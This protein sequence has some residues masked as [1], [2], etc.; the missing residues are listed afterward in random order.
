M[1]T[2]KKLGDRDAKCPYFRYHT[3]QNIVCEGAIPDTS[4][5]ILFESEEEKEKHYKIYCAEKWT[6]CEQAKRTGQQYADE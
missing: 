6:Y 4:V 2:Q 5:R 3:N 1:A